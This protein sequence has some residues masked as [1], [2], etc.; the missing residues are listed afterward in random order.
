MM[1]LQ[2]ITVT[3]EATKAATFA[4]PMAAIWAATLVIAS[5][6][7]LTAIARA[8]IANLPLELPLASVRP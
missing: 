1:A 3:T 7:G 5:D 6:V 2:E 4:A 8:S